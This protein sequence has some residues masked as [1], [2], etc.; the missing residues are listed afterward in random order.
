MWLIKKSIFIKLF[1]VGLLFVFSGCAKNEDYLINLEK[2]KS[3]PKI[4]LQTEELA[5]WIFLEEINSYNRPDGL[6]EIE[7]RFQ[8]NSNSNEKLS[9]KIDWRD[10]NGF[11]YKS[12]LSKWIVVEVE[13]N[14]KLIIKGIS[15][16][17]KVRDF[18]IRIQKPTADDTYRKNQNNNQYQGN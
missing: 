14:R 13:E 8:N 6:L 1:V 4:I 3:E 16:S 7:A 2:F 11:T 10:E 17:I 5:E 15:P 12:I 9:Y 18:R